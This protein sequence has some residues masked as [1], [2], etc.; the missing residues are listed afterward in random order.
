MVL[1]QEALDRISQLIRFQPEVFQR[2]T[3]LS[4]YLPV[5]IMLFVVGAAVFFWQWSGS[6]KFRIL[7]R[8][9]RIQ[10]IAIVY[11]FI[12]FIVL[13]WFQGC[14]TL[15]SR[16]QQIPGGFVDP[17]QRQ[18]VPTPANVFTT[19]AEVEQKV[20]A[21]LPGDGATLTYTASGYFDTVS[22]YKSE[23]GIQCFFPAGSL[24]VPEAKYHIDGAQL[25]V[26]TDS[27]PGCYLFKGKAANGEPF[28]VTIYFTEPVLDPAARI[29]KLI[30]ETIIRGD[31]R[32]IQSIKTQ[33][34]HEFNISLVLEQGFANGTY[35]VSALKRPQYSVSIS[36]PDDQTKE[37]IQRFA[38]AK[39][40]GIVQVQ[41]S[42]PPTLPTKGA[43]VALNSR[44]AALYSVQSPTALGVT[45]LYPDPDDQKE[46]MS[47]QKIENWFGLSPTEAQNLYVNAWAMSP[48]GGCRILPNSSESPNLAEDV[49]RV[50]ENPTDPMF[51]FLAQLY[52]KN[53]KTIVLNSEAWE[54]PKMLSSDNTQSQTSAPGDII[55]AHILPFFK[56]TL[57]YGGASRV[58]FVHGKIKN[59]DKRLSRRPIQKEEVRTASSIH[60]NKEVKDAVY[61]AKTWVP[62]IAF[63]DKSYADAFINAIYNEYTELL[64]DPTD[65][66]THL[67][68]GKNL[69]QH[70]DSLLKL[71]RGPRLSD[72]NWYKGAP[73]GDPKE[74]NRINRGDGKYYRLGYA[75]VGSGYTLQKLAI[76]YC[77]LKVQNQPVPDNYMFEWMSNPRDF[78]KLE[79]DGEGGG[80]ISFLQDAELRWGS[81][82]LRIDPFS[83]FFTLLLRETYPSSKLF[84]P[85]DNLGESLVDIA[86]RTPFFTTFSREPFV[87]DMKT[88]GSYL[89]EGDQYFKKAT[90][91]VAQAMADL[92][93]SAHGPALFKMAE[94]TI[95]NLSRYQE[96]SQTGLLQIETGSPIG[97]EWEYLVP[98]RNGNQVELV[99]YSRDKDDCSS[100]EDS[101]S[102][103]C[104]N[105]VKSKCPDCGGVPELQFIEKKKF[106]YKPGTYNNPFYQNYAKFSMGIP[107]ASNSPY[108][109]KTPDQVWKVRD[110]YYQDLMKRT[111]S[112]DRVALK[113]FIDDMRMHALY[114]TNVGGTLL[115]SANTRVP[116]E[117]I[118]NSRL[119]MDSSSNQYVPDP[120]NFLFTTTNGLSGYRGKTY[121]YEPALDDPDEDEAQWKANCI[122][123]NGN[124]VPRGY[125]PQSDK[126]PNLYENFVDSLNC[127]P[128]TLHPDIGWKSKTFDQVKTEGWETDN[129]FS[130]VRKSG[131]HYFGTDE[132]RPALPAMFYTA[133]YD[134][135]EF[136]IPNWIPKSARNENS[137][138]K[139]LDSTPL[140]DQTTLK[141]FGD[142]DDHHV[143][144]VFLT[145][146][147]EAKVEAGDPIQLID[148]NRIKIPPSQETWLE[149]SSEGWGSIKVKPKPDK[150]AIKDR[151]HLRRGACLWGYK[152][153]YDSYVGMIGTS[154]G[155]QDHYRTHSLGFYYCADRPYENGKAECPVSG[156]PVCS[157][158]PSV[159]P[160]PSPSTSPTPTP[161]ATP[162]PSPTPCDSG[163]YLASGSACHITPTPSIHPTNTPTVTPTS[164]PTPSPSP[165]TTPTET[166]TPT[167]SVAPT[168]DME[169][170]WENELDH[171]DDD[172]QIEPGTIE[173]LNCQAN[174][175]SPSPSVS[176]TP[177]PTR[178]P[179]PTVQPTQPPNQSDTCCL[180]YCNPVGNFCDPENDLPCPYNVPCVDH[181]C[182]GPTPTP[183]PSVTVTPTVTRTPTPT[184]TKTPTPTMTIIPSPSPTGSITP[185]KPPSPTPTKI[186][187][188]TPTP[189]CPPGQVWG[190]LGTGSSGCHC[191]GG[192]CQTNEHCTAPQVCKI[193]PGTTCG[194]CVITTPTPTP[195][196]TVCPNSCRVQNPSCS[197]FPIGSSCVDY[198]APQCPTCECPSGFTTHTDSLH[199]E[200]CCDPE[201]PVFT[202]NCP[203]GTTFSDQGC[204]VCSPTPTP[205][206]ITPTPSR[207]NPSPTGTSP[208]PTSTNT[209]TG[210]GTATPTVA[211]S[212]TVK[213]SPTQPPTPTGCPPDEPLVDNQCCPQGQIGTTTN[214]TRVCCGTMDVAVQGNNPA[215][216]DSLSPKMRGCQMPGYTVSYDN[217]KCGECVP[218]CNTPGY[219]FVPGAPNNCCADTQTAITSSGKICCSLPEKAFIDKCCKPELMRNGKCCSPGDCAING[220]YCATIGQECRTDNNACGD[221]V[222]PT[223]T[224]TPNNCPSNRISNIDGR[225]CASTD[226]IV[227]RCVGGTNPIYVEDAQHPCG[228]CVTPTPTPTVVCPPGQSIPRDSKGNP[229]G[230][231]CDNSKIG[232]DTNG[233]QWCC[234]GSSTPASSANEPPCCQPA[235]SSCT[236]GYTIGTDS[237]NAC[238]HCVP[239]CNLSGYET[240]IGA[241]NNCCLSSQV[242]VTSSG[243]K[244]CCSDSSKTP[245]SGGSSSNCCQS[246]LVRN[247][248]CCSASDPVITLYCPPN[249][250]LTTEHTNCGECIPITP[251]PTC[252]PAPTSCT[253][254]YT[255]GTDSTSSCTHCIRCPEVT[256]CPTGMHVGLDATSTCAHC[257]PDPS[258]SPTRS[259]SP[260][261]SRAPSPTPTV[262]PTGTGSS[263][264]SSTLTPTPSPTPTATPT[265]TGSS[266][267]SSTST[268]TGTS[269]STSTG[270]TTGISTSTGTG[271]GTAH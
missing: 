196:S 39:A 88:I 267:G 246:S 116:C 201:D 51:C 146:K 61:E 70:I 198:P 161:S 243:T 204:G 148:R 13:G 5:L 32:S 255:L 187:S 120:K 107:V 271:T 119:A 253:T 269:S 216:C 203:P 68:D 166:P 222:K 47:Y 158:T 192:T 87:Q 48:F 134:N 38:L 266:T 27:Q 79:Q 54:D 160:T 236:T 94:P 62:L 123:Q 162:A 259:P 75:A 202:H 52:R 2:L 177:S 238:P 117:G 127:L 74:Q 122:G 155:R 188:P 233:A 106:F 71:H 138:G 72:C 248:T 151:C 3:G 111:N 189:V 249:T 22:I 263:T 220:G 168:Q 206:P 8:S 197:G 144:A 240:V 183:S 180:P 96:G 16:S 234:G 244:F 143:W 186:L 270:S 154:A 23:S 59:N 85:F 42:A 169:C 50:P 84:D 241:P 157:P 31:S 4:T 163:Y 174:V 82:R 190:D 55:R 227:N 184:V 218:G 98:T 56:A 57:K 171:P 43:I 113:Q 21:S 18:F 33:V 145:E 109:L 91:F 137:H 140:D 83:T 217:N 245:I 20:S 152:D 235:P 67:Y 14:S 90:Y 205:T 170:P 264:G 10:S 164:S 211:P 77:A 40:S 99:L 17:N 76:D 97:L 258:P 251:T 26:D 229:T 95:E 193:D 141:E 214:G 136:T 265:S 256:S 30:D 28:A 12:G 64:G 69:N 36:I 9:S 73:G 60:F 110:A 104:I 261:P 102:V 24:P 78:V 268:R 260:T 167:P 49:V 105:K 195:T 19:I 131:W 252:R 213:P 65:E 224:P 250:T 44:I 242:G 126:S 181:C 41:S 175:P 25:V 230:S 101:S 147:M 176:P 228:T 139:Y 34:E 93:S 142:G 86:D 156:N 133:L 172:C 223:P 45:E 247:G 165:T 262:V 1:K 210:T 232:R 130:K 199:L 254:G 150:D 149:P 257:I 124:Q 7:S 81:N 63:K 221:C 226:A 200:Y 115:S 80:V 100:E 37:S 207:P 182:A 239:G 108:C 66:K 208:T 114:A 215:C 179:T 35:N 53:D 212:P 185:T 92:R 103:E 58:A 125:L 173:G 194:S 132:Y 209:S 237:S 11:S 191:P 29:R 178:N 118:F 153:V 231:C 128:A 89:P 219:Q 46:A 121:G 15:D 159:S 129:N 135:A 6:E 112:N 225:C